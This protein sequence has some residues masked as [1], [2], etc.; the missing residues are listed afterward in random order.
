MPKLFNPTPNDTCFLCG[1]QA[2]WI[3][4]NSKQ[5]RCVEK[6]TQCTGFVKK[7]QATRDAN[8]TPEERTAHMKRMSKNG[9]AKLKKLYEDHEWA[10]TQS[11]KISEA[12]EKRGGHSG[13]NN[14][15]FG[16][17]HKQSTKR[18]QAIKAQSRDPKCY[19]QATETKIKNGIATPKNLKTAWNLYR[20][21]VENITTKSWKNHH[22]KINPNNLPRGREYELDHKFSKTE[23]FLNNVAPEVIGHHAN[24][25]LIPKNENRSKRTKC[26][27]TLTELYKVI[28]S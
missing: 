6:I 24:L 9:N 26:S 28:K 2:H 7:A 4:F 5:M 11:K 10:T 19:E 12:V 17:T 15:M 14:P 27:T 16:K 21:K 22:N 20:E 3:S 25:E 8:T 1:C 18:K 23:G 13:S